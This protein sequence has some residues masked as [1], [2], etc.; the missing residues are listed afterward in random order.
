MRYNPEMK[1]TTCDHRS[2]NVIYEEQQIYV[3]SS[4]CRYHCDHG[5]CRSNLQAAIIG[6]AH[7]DFPK[8]KD[9]EFVADYLKRANRRNAVCDLDALV[10]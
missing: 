10:A 4:I 8:V 3:S 5:R 7:S 2:D 9:G 1:C 6:W